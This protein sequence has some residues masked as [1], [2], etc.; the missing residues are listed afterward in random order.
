M[1]QNSA[2]DKGKGK[3]IFSNLDISKAEAS[4]KELDNDKSADAG[5]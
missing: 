4:T 1:F 3:G 5:D 2:F